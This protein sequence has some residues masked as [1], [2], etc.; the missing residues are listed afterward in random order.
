MHFVACG[1][2]SAGYQVG[3]GSLIRYPSDSVHGNVHCE[4][5]SVGTLV[6]MSAAVKEQLLVEQL[7]FGFLLEALR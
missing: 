5:C 3:E 7:R 2:S 6:A 1:V 4:G